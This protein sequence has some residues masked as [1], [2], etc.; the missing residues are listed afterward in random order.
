MVAGLPRIAE[1]AGFGTEPGPGGYT[2][3]WDTPEEP[4]YDHT[5]IWDAPN[6]QALR[7]W[8]DANQILGRPRLH[9]VLGV[10]VYRGVSRGTTFV[11]IDAEP[12]VELRVWAMHY[13]RAGRAGGT[14]RGATFQ[15]RAVY[16]DA[17]PKEAGGGGAD[18]VAITESE[19][20]T[21]G[22]PD[23]AEDTDTVY[24]ITED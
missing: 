6:D 5:R 1:P 19:Y 20:T 23:G 16:A 18:V 17:I 2:A 14:R 24:L 7:D 15:E 3:S 11:R 8:Y 4:D 22:L 9:A 13:D 10:G 12:E 21:D